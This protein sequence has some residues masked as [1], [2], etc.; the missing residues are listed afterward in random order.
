[1]GTLHGTKDKGTDFRECLPS[2]V[3]PAPVRTNFWQ[4]T[5]RRH[6]TR[7]SGCA[8]WRRTRNA[9]RNLGFVSPN[10]VPTNSPRTQ[11]RAIYSAAI[12][13]TNL[14]ATQKKK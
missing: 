6:R 10:L 3:W 7:K 12:V 5:H 9:E 13:S 8:V 11:P 4:R 1:M 2:F 14:L